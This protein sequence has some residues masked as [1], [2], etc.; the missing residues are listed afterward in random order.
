LGNTHADLDLITAL[1]R[2]DRLANREARDLLMAGCMINLILYY[3][4]MSIITYLYL[5]ES[6]KLVEVEKV[7][8]N[9]MPIIDTEYKY[10]SGSVINPTTKEC[11]KET[12]EYIEK[13]MKWLDSAEFILRETGNED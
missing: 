5:R 7:Q 6:D 11:G 3:Q 8:Q 12:L 4:Q 13:R 10:L 1:I 9:L 2:L